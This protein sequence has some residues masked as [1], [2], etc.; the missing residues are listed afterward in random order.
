MSKYDR[1]KSEFIIM[2]NFKHALILV[3]LF[4]L[5]SCYKDKTNPLA[6]ATTVSYQNEIA[7]IMSNSCASGLGPGV[8]CHDSWILKYSGVVNAINIGSYQSTIFD[9]KSMPK[10]PNIYNID[11]LT[12]NELETIRCWVNQGYPNN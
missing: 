9:L 7:P 6:C 3:S 1:L 11:S 2:L 4:W 8:A 10:I 12:S 5:S